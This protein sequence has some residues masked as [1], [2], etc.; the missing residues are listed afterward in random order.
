MCRIERTVRPGG[1]GVSATLRVAKAMIHE[2]EEP[3][4]IGTLKGEKKG[5]GAVFFSGCNLKCVFCQNYEISWE[6]H[7]EEISGT[8]LREI[9]LELQEQGA[10]SL[11]LVTPTPWLPMIA[12]ALTDLRSSG[13][14]KI[15]VVFNCGGY[16][17]AEALRPLEGLVDIYMPDLKY[18]DPELSKRYS[19][20]LDY[21][22]QASAAL[23]EMYRQTG[24][25]QWANTP[26]GQEPAAPDAQM[27]KGLLIRHLVLPGCSGDSVRLMEYL[28]KAF[29]KD[30]IRISLLSQYTPFGHLEAFPELQRRVT[31]YEYEKVLKAADEA[32]LL[33]YR[34]LRS[35]A[36]MDLRPSFDG[37]GVRPEKTS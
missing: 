37:S 18:M 11:D 13:Q 3:C 31:T 10:A 7:G 14:L 21:F 9:F 1:C 36:T 30:A 17:R 12:D 24:P 27:T 6:R 23:Q 29:P 34:Q 22:E 28:G 5:A 8:R 2:G 33:G 35:S 26:A 19:G 32:G 16:E 15:P 20:A 25:V 4:L